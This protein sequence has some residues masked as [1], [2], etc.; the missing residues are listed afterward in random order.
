MGGGWGVGVLLVNL[1]YHIYR[2]SMDSSFHLVQ[3]LSY[4]IEIKV[5]LLTY[6]INVYFNCMISALNVNV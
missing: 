5:F 2:A 3:K 6:E 4:P 1:V